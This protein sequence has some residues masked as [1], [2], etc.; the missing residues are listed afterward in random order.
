M[1]GSA[2]LA[3]CKFN[4]YPID[5]WSKATLA[6]APLFSVTWEAAASQSA[7]QDAF[8][9]GYRPGS[10][11]TQVGFRKRRKLLRLQKIGFLDRGAVRG[12]RTMCSGVH[13]PSMRAL[14][15]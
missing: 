13:L 6:M 14:A 5:T 2:E 7:S 1:V 3:E 12:F 15:G 8:G 4:E 9:G 10:Q 11:M